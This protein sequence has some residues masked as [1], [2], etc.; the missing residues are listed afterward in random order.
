MTINRRATRHLQGNSHQ[1]HPCRQTRTS[2]SSRKPKLSKRELPSP[3]SRNRTF[4]QLELAGNLGEF[5]WLFQRD[6]VLKN[7]CAFGVSL[8]HCLGHFFVALPKLF[9]ALVF[10]KVFTFLSPLSLP[11]SPPGQVFVKT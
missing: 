3:T 1:I 6:L 9:C 10:S 7:P 2:C 5:L 8:Q 4:K 11:I